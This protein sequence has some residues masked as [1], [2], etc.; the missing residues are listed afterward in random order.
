MTRSPE[1]GS[2]LPEAT[3]C[4]WPV[5]LPNL[6]RRGGRGPGL[7]PQLS[8]QRATSGCLA[9]AE[10]SAQPQDPLPESSSLSTLRDGCTCRGP[11]WLWTRAPELELS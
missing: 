7:L 11:G 1:P 6:V 3:S 8:E 10:F 4:T 2:P 5:L 9:L